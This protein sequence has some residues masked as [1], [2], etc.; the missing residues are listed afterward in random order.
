MI[1]YGCG[2][3]LAEIRQLHLCDINLDRKVITVRMGKGR[4]DRIV[5]LDDDLAPEMNSWLAS[6]CCG[7]EYLFEGYVPGKAISKGFGNN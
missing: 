6:R 3:R 4:K 2:L 1:A 5:M 7:R